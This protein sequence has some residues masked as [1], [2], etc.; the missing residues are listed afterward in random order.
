MELELSPLSFFESLLESDKYETMKKEYMDDY[1]RDF[2]DLKFSIGTIDYENAIIVEDKYT[3]LT[4]NSD[5]TQRLTLEL[6]KAK[7]NIDKNVIIITSNNIS[8][9][10]FLKIQLRVINSLLL[11]TNILYINQPC[12]KQAITDLNNHIINKYNVSSLLHITDKINVNSFN[13]DYLDNQENDTR[14]KIS[15]LYNELI[16]I[17]IISGTENDFVNGFMGK[18]VLEGIRWLP[19]T[20]DDKNTAKSTLF[21]FIDYLMN[22]NF[23][24][25]LNGKEYNDAIEYV[26]R[27]YNGNTL[28]NIRQSKS[29]STASIPENIQEIINNL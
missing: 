8:P 13:W 28:K 4:F 9:N 20:K 17:N 18:P 10:E 25:K 3:T 22:E 23:I 11:K 7:E 21:S 1:I 24:L 12:V 27:D 15:S 14:E 26:F 5:F 29:S 16:A 6:S 2:G 19:R